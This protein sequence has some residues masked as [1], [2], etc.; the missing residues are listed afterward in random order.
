MKPLK[1]FTFMI[2]LFCSAL[3]PAKAQVSA[4]AILDACLSEGDEIANAMC[5]FYIVGSI[6]GLRWGAEAAGIQSGI[7]DA[8]AMLDQAHRFLSA[9]TPEAATSNQLYEVAL[10]YMRNHPERWHEPAIHLIHL[11]LKDAFPCE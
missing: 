3:S 1:Y 8:Q 7:T 11:A 5:R 9:C 6:D 4:N 10:K 2:A